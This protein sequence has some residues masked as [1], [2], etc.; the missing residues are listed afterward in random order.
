MGVLLRIVWLVILFLFVRYIVNR[1]L[2]RAAPRSDPPP[3]QIQG[4]VHKDPACGIYVAEELA[5]TAPVAGEKRYF[6]SP[7]CRDRFLRGES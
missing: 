6:C 4:T 5:V 3:P 7:E 2:R 1:L